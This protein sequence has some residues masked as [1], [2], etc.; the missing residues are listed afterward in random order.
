MFEFIKSLFVAKP[1]ITLTH[2]R[3]GLLTYDSG[4]W[5]GGARS[6]DRTIHFVVGGTQ[7][8][9]DARLLDSLNEVMKRFD[10]VERE[11]LEF[12]LASVN[13]AER[14]TLEF[15][16]NEASGVGPNDFSFY[17]LD[18]LWEAQPH[19]FV[20]EFILEGDVD[21]IWRVE[22]ENGRPKSLGRD[23]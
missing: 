4:L 12:I 10:D 1:R 16:R 2:Q 20:V 19:D 8:E 17:S 9:P 5:S 7:A 13:G 14:E 15:F 23:D 6:R 18:F 11:A 21:G 22:F 3:F